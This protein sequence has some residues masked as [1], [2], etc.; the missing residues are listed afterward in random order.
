[1]TSL[2]YAVDE[3]RLRNERLH[4]LLLLSELDKTYRFVFGVPKA[5]LVERMCALEIELFSPPTGA[6]L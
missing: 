3:A 2:S 1:M 5:S 6:P 4:E